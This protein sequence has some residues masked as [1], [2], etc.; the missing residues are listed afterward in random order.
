MAL[1][2]V[3]V[4]RVALCLS[5]AAARPPALEP[6]A[7]LPCAVVMVALAAPLP[8]VVA[9]DRRVSAE[10]S[11][12]PLVN[13][14][15]PVAGHCSCALVLV[16]QVVDRCDLML[17]WPQRRVAVTCHS[18]VVLALTVVPRRYAVVLARRDQVVP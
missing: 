9:L 10:T 18:R 8:C 14:R 12:L 6:A 13:R 3:A 16:P 7:L 17:V 1:E 15:L 11:P 2:P 4:A 5:R